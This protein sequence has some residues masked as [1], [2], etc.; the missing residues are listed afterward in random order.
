[1]ALVS[2][3]LAGAV[4]LNSQLGEFFKTIIGIC[5]ECLLSPI[6]FNLFMEMIMQETPH[7]HHTSISI[8][9]RPIC[10]PRFA[11]G[12]DLMSGTN[13]EL[14]DLANRLVD[15]AWAYEMDVSTEKSTVL[16]KR[17]NNINAD[18]SMNGQKS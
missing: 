17:T 7:G 9:G 14:Q 16:T 13:G 12:V 3:D 6:L 4:L 8:G 1:M 18:I 15:R 2:I 11:D 10:N 5:Q